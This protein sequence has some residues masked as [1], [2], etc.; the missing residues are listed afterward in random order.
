MKKRIALLLCVC[1]ASALML[2]ACANAQA[3][4]LDVVYAGGLEG[5]TSAAPVEGFA[6]GVT[7]FSLELFKEAAQGETKNVFLSPA[8]VAL[9]LGMTQSGARGDTA[10]EMR[11]ALGLEELSSQD[12]NEGFRAMAE[13]LERK[14]EKTEVRLSNALWANKD[15]KIADG[16]IADNKQY[17]GAALANLDF[18]SPDA[19]RIINDWVKEK[20]DGK[21]DGIVDQIDRD[22]ILFIMNAIWFEGSW[23]K[24]FD[25]DATSEAAFYGVD[26]EA[27]VQMMR[28][29][30]IFEH[31]NVDGGQ[32]ISLPY[33]DGSLAMYVFL[34]D[35][36]STLDAAVS[37]LD[38]SVWSGWIDSREPK[39][40]MIALPQFK[41]EYEA[42]LKE[43][44]TALGM[45]NVFD[46][47]KADFTG[48]AQAAYIHDVRHKAFIDVDE[49]GTRAAAVTSVEMRVTSAAPTE[50]TFTMT[51]DRPF[52]FAIAEQET[53]TILFM[54]AIKN[55]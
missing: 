42:Y 34:P 6:K 28:Q 11:S 29:E 2:G 53:G 35:K 25:P 24:Q 7:G 21:I 14:D 43:T 20:T 46:S 38:E 31:A 44:L 3:Q 1:L 47:D 45:A 36:E 32:F 15:V 41:L 8:S 33:G 26:G 12:V 13:A 17:Y 48:I 55:L 5:G 37:A 27:K 16:F 50:D 4:G 23:S 39:Q 22:T 54:G 18:S 9:A 51:V 49:K 40:G 52:L 19:V 10:E 30:D